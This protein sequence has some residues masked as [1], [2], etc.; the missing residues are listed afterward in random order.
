MFDIL[1]YNAADVAILQLSPCWLLMFLLPRPEGSAG[2]QAGV[3]CMG[4][5]LAMS[6]VLVQHSDNLKP[7]VSAIMLHLSDIK[8]KQ[9]KYKES[10]YFLA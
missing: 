1:V 6:K 10:L 5:S 3:A 9:C 4:G 2:I 8:E 7:K